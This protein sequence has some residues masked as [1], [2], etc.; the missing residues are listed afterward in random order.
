MIFFNIY[1][2][3]A[4]GIRKN[5]LLFIELIIHPWPAYT[6]LFVEFGHFQSIQCKNNHFGLNG[7]KNIL[8]V[9]CWDAK[10]DNKI[11][12]YVC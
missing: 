8:R 3:R 4:F 6:Y 10:L 1:E 11:K 7:N 5:I 2:T 12:K 9:V